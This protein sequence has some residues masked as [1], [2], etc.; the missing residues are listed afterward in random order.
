MA[1]VPFSDLTPTR[2]IWVSPDGSNSNDGSRAHPYKTI[3]YA[4]DHARPGRAFF[5]MTG[6]YAAN[7]EFHVSGLADKPI[8]LTSADG[9]GAALIT[10]GRGTTTATIEAFGEDYIVINGFNVS[11]GDRN[12]N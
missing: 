12:T 11:G 9:R 2:K 10:H 7:V 5:V 1:T 4:L 6:T 3:Q 8:W